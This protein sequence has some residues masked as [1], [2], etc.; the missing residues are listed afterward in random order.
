MS[1]GV[2]LLL[3]PAP[4]QVQGKP[5]KIARPIKMGPVPRAKYDVE[6]ADGT[7]SYGVNPQ[8]IMKA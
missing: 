2:L 7:V 1:A 8:L 6:Y 5:G 4:A 3:V